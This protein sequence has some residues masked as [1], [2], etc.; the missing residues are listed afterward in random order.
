MDR[1]S[2]VSGP[3]WV[4]SV[5]VLLGAVTVV[6]GF[7]LMRTL[8]VEMA[9]YLT[10]VRDVDSMLVGA[11]G[12]GLFL[13]VFLEP[14]VRRAL[15]PRNALIAVVIALG[16][17]RLVEQT[18]SPLAV[19]LAHTSVGAELVLS[20]LGLSAVGTVLFLW[21]LPLLFRSIGPASGHGS[22][23]HAAIALLL[24]LSADT[25]L[26]GVFGTIEVSWVIGVAGYLVVMALWLAQTLLLIQLLSAPF[27]RER[28]EEQQQERTTFAWPY[29][30]FGPALALE[31]LLFQNVAHQTVVI[32][33]PQPAVYAL[34]VAAN[35]L[36]VAV[37]VE[38]A[39]WKRSLPWPILALLGGLLVAMVAV[40]RSGPLAALTVVVGQTAIAIALASIVRGTRASSAGP[41]NDGAS[42]WLGAGMLL[43]LALLFIYYAGYDT[44]VLVPREAV[45][46]LAA[47][48]VG[49]AA[50]GAAMGR[51]TGGAPVTRAASLPALLLLM[52]PLLHIAAWKSVEP[53]PGGGFPIRVMSYNL[54]QGFDVHGRHGMESLA[55][56]IEAE[57]PDIVALQEVSRGWVVNGS[58]DMLSWLS[59][60]L[61]MDYVWGPASDPVWG[62]AVLSRFPITEFQNHEM[63]N[64][65]VIRLDRSYLTANVDLGGG[66]TLDVVATHFHAGDEDSPIRVPQARAVLDAIDSDRTMVLIGDLNAHPDHPE[67]LLMSAAGLLDTFVSSG[68]PG[69]GFTYPADAPWKRIDY[70]WSSPDLKARDHSNPDSQASDHLA[71]AVTLYR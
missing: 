20:S 57:D 4:S 60:R 7:Q 55:K 16:A 63:P 64:N 12:L 54:H 29:L 44:D 30:A 42:I 27:T 58:V 53:T 38:L 8:F 52:L 24:G 1:L 17:V 41:S 26:K 65:D 45:R 19:D 49:L 21:S 39:R 2:T 9:V 18:I 32:G 48:L 37:A 40:D 3:A 47:L 10:Q 33:W 51:R 62:N 35:L 6:F 69:N 15:G 70:I 71:V 13:C 43:M 28:R 67:M 61:D 5:S 11:M 14:L 22:A 36:G 56:V 23:P 46:P 31:L 66:E 25:A 34:I 50:V 59:Q 68:A